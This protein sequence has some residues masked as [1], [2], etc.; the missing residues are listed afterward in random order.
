MLFIIIISSLLVYAT[1]VSSMFLNFAALQFLQCIDNSAYDMAEGGYL[2][3]SLEET[4]K[5]VSETT[6]PTCIE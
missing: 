3:D 2:T 1:D 6:L 4:A 5:Q